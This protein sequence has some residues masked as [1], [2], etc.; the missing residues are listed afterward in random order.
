[1]SSDDDNFPATPS[2]SGWYPVSDGSDQETFWDGKAWTRRRQYR[3][4]S[5][6]LEIP[7]HRSDPPLAPAP[8]PT[9]PASTSP[10]PT[11]TT[12]SPSLLNGNGPSVESMTRAFA[13]N[14]ESHSNAPSTSFRESRQRIRFIQLIYLIPF[15]GIFFLTFGR[16]AVGTNPE[17]YFK[18]LFVLGLVVS[19]IVR[20]ASSG[21]RQTVRDQES[22][23]RPK[24]PF[25][26]LSRLTDGLQGTRLASFVGGMRTQP[27]IGPTG[28]NATVPMAR[29]SVFSNGVRVGPSS[30][31]L[32][33]SVPTWEA[34]F[35]ELDVIQAIGRLQG[36]TTGILFRKSKS[37][38]WV[39]FW[40]LHRDAVFTTFEQMGIT[41]SREPVR[42]RAGS[43]W[44][45]NQFVEDELHPSEPSVLGLVN[46]SNTAT[47]GP[48]RAS[49]S[50]VFAAPLTSSAPDLTTTAQEDRKWPGVVVGVFGALFVI[51][52]FA[53][54][55][56]LVTGNP[57]PP[58]VENGGSS[59]T[60]VTTPVPVVTVS[61]AEWRTSV[62]QNAGYLVAPLAGIPNSI[63]HLRYNYGVTGNSFDLSDLT[64]G[65]QSMSTYCTM[66]RNF[67]VDGAP[68]PA[69]AK[70]AANVGVA[71]V[72]LVSVDEVDLNSAD[73]KWTPKLASNDQHW[74]KILKERV[75]VLKNGAAQ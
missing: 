75:A 11:T 27:R 71:C 16:H 34:R 52:T 8:G 25:R 74:L 43:Q 58:G 47:V 28:F 10:V 17:K 62:E 69:L 38:E 57:S 45:V 26:Y 29:L 32:S 1:M 55:F 70:D 50:L 36:L 66:F 23:R 51:S 46:T 48:S 61:P 37:H 72:D 49:S 65:L 19:L 2:T 40:T 73:N 59:V 22:D 15:V 41:V 5:P 24:W 6:F 68:S 4:G 42:L 54:V 7:L 20:F 9:T 33:I 35:D 13:Q 63:L 18:I 31:L 30:S 3:F 53:L 56:N 14:S 21:A 44:R 67:S 64:S 12:T 39:I 60:T